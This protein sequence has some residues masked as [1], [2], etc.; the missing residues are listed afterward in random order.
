MSGNEGRC[1]L[2]YITGR[3]TQHVCTPLAGS[4]DKLRRGHATLQQLQLG[5]H[6]SRRV[7]SP[8]PSSLHPNC[9]FMLH[10]CYA[11]ATYYTKLP[12]LSSVVIRRQNYFVLWCKKEPGYSFPDLFSPEPKSVATVAT[13]NQAEKTI[14]KCFPP[15]DLKNSHSYPVTCSQRPRRTWFKI[16]GAKLT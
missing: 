13:M 6:W 8:S 4:P 14:L 1:R 12:Y 16:L 2:G 3:I 11:A 15:S 5:S 10:E 7:H 9:H